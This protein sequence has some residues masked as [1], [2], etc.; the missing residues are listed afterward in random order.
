LSLE[1]QIRVLDEQK[2]ELQ[3][4]LNFKASK[5]QDLEKKLADSSAEIEHLDVELT[6]R[7]GTVQ[8]LEAK[9]AAKDKTIEQLQAMLQ[10]LSQ[11]VRDAVSVPHDR[12]EKD[13]RMTDAQS[14]DE[15]GVHANWYR[16]ESDSVDRQSEASTH[17][18]AIRTFKSLA[19]EAP[20]Y[21]D[22]GDHGSSSHSIESSHQAFDDIASDTESEASVQDSS[23]RTG[24]RLP[25]Q[26]PDHSS[27]SHGI[28][29][30]CQAVHDGD[31][32]MSIDIESEIPVHDSSMRNDIHL[33]NEVPDHGSR[34][35]SIES[36]RQAV[37]DRDAQMALTSIERGVQRRRREFSPS[38][39]GYARKKRKLETCVPSKLP[40]EERKTCVPSKRRMKK[41]RHRINREIRQ[42]SCRTGPVADNVPNMTPRSDFSFESNV[43]QKEGSLASSQGAAMD[44]ICCGSPE[45]SSF[46]EGVYDTDDEE[47]L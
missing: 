1:E 38:T 21:V 15:S 26:M 41:L 36:P 33:P 46:G 37:H 45:R 9:L 42:E 14:D 39:S 18:P 11:K 16:A 8:Q 47:S 6:T 43:F 13:C 31:V 24:T 19:D 23:M 10:D 17:S 3:L 40:V 4:K 22:L 34:R 27:S 35:Q 28:E 32:Q 2:S 29:N 30:P 44:E 12:R 25:N 7:N 20:E 5:I